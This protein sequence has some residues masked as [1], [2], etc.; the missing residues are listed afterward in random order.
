MATGRTAAGRRPL[1]GLRRRVR[2]HRRRVWERREQRYYR[3]HSAEVDASLR[4][5][6]LRQAHGAP[7]RAQSEHQARRSVSPE[8]GPERWLTVVTVALAAAGG[9]LAGCH[10]TA[11]PVVDPIET[12]LFAAGFT[13]LVA[14]AA[15]SV[16][17]VVGITA[18]LLAR[19][20]PLAAP[21]LVVLVVALAGVVVT[22]SRP[23]AGAVVGAMGVQVVLRWPAHFFHGFTAAIG[24]GLLALCAVSAWRRSSQRIRRRAVVTVGTVVAE[25]PCARSSWSWPR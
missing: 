23:W 25:R 13:M 4:H 7:R 14:R 22:R 17:L 12:A 1:R 2:R 5:S 19:G 3:R 9:A 21:A 16:W 24:A 6:H 20:H 11:T 15:P 10:P 8:T 18:F